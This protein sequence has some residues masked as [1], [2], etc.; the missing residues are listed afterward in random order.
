LHDSNPGEG[1]GDG[2]D[3]KDRVFGYAPVRRDVRHPLAVEELERSV[4]YHSDCETNSRSA[5]EDLVN[6]GSRLQL[7]DIGHRLILSGCPTVRR[8]LAAHCL[9]TTLPISAPR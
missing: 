7:I 6:P 9:T 8:L 1:L 3:P 4:A 5:V 2:R